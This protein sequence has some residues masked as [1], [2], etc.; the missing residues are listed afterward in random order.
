M[1]IVKIDLTLI[2]PNSQ[3]LFKKVVSCQERRRTVLVAMKE[4]ESKIQGQKASF[5]FLIF[6]SQ[7]FFIDH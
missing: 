5:W 2:T 4:G 3:F 6:W 7:F 1:E